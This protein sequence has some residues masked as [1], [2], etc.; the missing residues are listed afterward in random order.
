MFKLHEHD[1]NFF[2][3][4]IKP[5]NF[6]L[7]QLLYFRSANIRVCHQTLLVLLFFIEWGFI[8]LIDRLVEVLGCVHAMGECCGGCEPCTHV[9]SLK[10]LQGERR[11]TPVSSSHC[12]LCFGLAASPVFYHLQQFIGSESRWWRWSWSHCWPLCVRWVELYLLS[13]CCGLQ[14]QDIS[15]N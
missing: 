8:R 5:L 4:F 3:T 6:K 14:L 10:L 15:V 7:S 9:L 13:Q 1:S 2:L 11:G 12:K